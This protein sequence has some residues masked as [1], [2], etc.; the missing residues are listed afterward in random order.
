MLS[1]RVALLSPL[2]LNR[3]TSHIGIW[4]SEVFYSA[5]KVLHFLGNVPSRDN[6]LVFFS[7]AIHPDW[8]AMLQR[9]NA[10]R[11]TYCVTVG[12]FLHARDVMPVEIKRLDME[13]S[14]E[15]DQDQPYVFTLPTSVKEIRSW[16][17]M[18][19]KVYHKEEYKRRAQEKD[20]RSFTTG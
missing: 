14:L 20:A 10:G 5:P 1:Y 9:Y 11:V 18:M 19:L 7:T 16:M 6:M 15:S 2:S 8:D 4:C 17:A 12:Q 3:P 13:L